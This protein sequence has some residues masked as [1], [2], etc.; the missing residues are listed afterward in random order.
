MN[1][2]NIRTLC[3]IK[4][5][6]THSV[7][8]FTLQSVHFFSLCSFLQ[9]SQ[10]I[11]N[12]KKLGSDK[13]PLIDQTFYPNYKDMVRMIFFFYTLYVVSNPAAKLQLSSN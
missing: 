9:F 8:M 13:F 7:F 1:N 2:M 5:Y 4:E 3:C 11:N 12:Q 6:C 10:L